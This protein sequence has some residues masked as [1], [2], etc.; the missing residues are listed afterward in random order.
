VVSC[1][2]E[3]FSA[4]P[5]PY[6]N[7]SPIH[8]LRM[9]HA[10]FDTAI[11]SGRRVDEE[12]VRVRQ[13]LDMTLFKRPSFSRFCSLPPEIQAMIWQLAYFLNPRILEIL[14]RDDIK[15]YPAPSVFN[16]SIEA[17]RVGEEFLLTL[18]DQTHPIWYNPYNL[19]I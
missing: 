1:T 17:R 5:K 18:G 7:F 12:T 4:R 9:V 14:S 15:G 19:S 3:R 11:T 2:F 6:L 16:T 13:S 10:P 8:S